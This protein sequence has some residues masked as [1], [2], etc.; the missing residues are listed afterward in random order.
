MRKQLLPAGKA[1]AKMAG[2]KTAALVL[3]R[4]GEDRVAIV[5]EPL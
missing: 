2:N 4:I 3:T 1:A 5:V